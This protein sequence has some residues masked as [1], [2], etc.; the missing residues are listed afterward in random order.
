MSISTASPQAQGLAARFDFARSEAIG[1]IL[2]VAL[3]IILP[4]MYYPVFLMKVLCFALFACSFNLLAGFTGLMSFGHAAFFGMGGYV[5]SYMAKEMGLTPEFAILF[6]GAAS[7][8]MGVVFGWM[9]IRRPGMMFAMITLAL[10]QMLYF[11]CLQAASFT[12]GEDGI[13]R[14]PR[15]FLFGSISLQNNLA[16]YAVV[17]VV[18]LVGFLLIHRTVHSPFGQVLMAIRDN[19]QRARSLGYNTNTYKLIAFVLASF[20]AGIAGG[21][22]SIV[23]G[24]ATLTDVSFVM[25]GQ[26]VLMTILGGIGTLF[27]PVIGA[28]LVI[29]IE[30]IL[31]HAGAWVSVAQGLIF[32][33]CVLVFRK[34]IVGEI[35]ARLKV[36]L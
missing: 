15:G 5:A 32:M 35:S 12:G 1:L 16:M 30:N 31:S 26:V 13:Q 20:L 18:F 23:F 21:T 25:S 9:S 8:A 29:C 33:V 17:A 2:M 24:I 19:E 3:I 6:A 22:K 34:G 7:A 4:M 11:F 36:K 27:G 28:L 10:A 14:V